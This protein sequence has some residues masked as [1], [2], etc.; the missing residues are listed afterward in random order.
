MEILEI[1]AAAFLIKNYYLNF[2]FF[3]QVLQSAFLKN[4]NK[5]YSQKD[6]SHLK[7]AC[8]SKRQKK[9]V[10]KTKRKAK[11]EKKSNKN[12]FFYFTF[13]CRKIYILVENRFEKTWFISLNLY[14]SLF[15]LACDRLLEIQ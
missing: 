8:H 5:K 2:I 4:E 1:F 11:N 9:N 15:V 13:L 12:N 6:A 10:E 7:V 14:Y 3:I